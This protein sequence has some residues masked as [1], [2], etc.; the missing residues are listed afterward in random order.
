VTRIGQASHSQQQSRRRSLELDCKFVTKER[1]S[2][3]ALIVC[4]VS[5]VTNQSPWIQAP[6]KRGPMTFS[7]EELEH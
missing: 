2:L 3:I 1:K 6:A 4:T 7:S 5:L